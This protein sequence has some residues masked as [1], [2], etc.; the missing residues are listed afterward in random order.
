MRY[1][2]IVNLLNQFGQPDYKGLDINNF[3]P[4]GQVYSPDNTTCIVATTDDTASSTS[5]DVT[6]LT[7]ADYTSTR[8]EMLS[9]LDANNKTTEQRIAELESQNAQMLLALVNG[10]LM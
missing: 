5:S 4:G 7:E 9:V 3:V 2:K 8:T 6:E 10:G 1:F